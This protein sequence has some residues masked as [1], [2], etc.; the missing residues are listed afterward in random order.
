[1]QGDGRSRVYFDRASRLVACA[2]RTSE[3]YERLLKAWRAITGTPVSTAVDVPELAVFMHLPDR[4][5]LNPY[6]QLY[7]GR[8]FDPETI[9]AESAG[10]AKLAEQVSAVR[11]ALRPAPLEALL[12][13]AAAS[14]DTLRLASH[15][16]KNHIAPV[17]EC[18]RAFEALLGAVDP[19]RK[20]PTAQPGA[21]DAARIVFLGQVASLNRFLPRPKHTALVTLASANVSA[22]QLTADEVRKAWERMDKHR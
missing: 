6:P 13:D 2:D 5:L 3:Q 17:V 19:A 4:V 7:P 12:Q 18:L 1:M 10:Y 22:T 11:A 15:F 16:Q 21:R 20:V 14:D 9:A 8:K